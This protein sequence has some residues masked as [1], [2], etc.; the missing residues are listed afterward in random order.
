MPVPFHTP[1]G[2]TEIDDGRYNGRRG[3]D[4]CLFHSIPTSP[5]DRPKWA[6]PLLPPAAAYICLPFFCHRGRA[7]I[8]VD[9]PGPCPQSLSLRDAP[10]SLLARRL[11]IRRLEEKPGIDSFC[12]L[13]EPVILTELD[14]E[15]KQSRAASTR[16]PTFRFRVSRPRRRSEPV[17]FGRLDLGRPFF[18]SA[19]RTIKKFWQKFLT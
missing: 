19:V 9:A 10:A 17:D 5:G 16:S 11:P 4:R 13:V 3:T 1:R 15:L 2:P 14:E 7:Q 8:L 12:R 18:S 6:R